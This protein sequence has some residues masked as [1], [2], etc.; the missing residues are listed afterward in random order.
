[1][2]ATSGAGFATA[3]KPAPASAGGLARAGGTNW[4][5]MMSKENGKPTYL[6]LLSSILSSSAG[7]CAGD[8]PKS[9][10]VSILDYVTTHEWTVPGSFSLS[11]SVRSGFGV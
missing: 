2:A 4:E 7:R 9:A 3:C 6:R 5:A 11:Q 10:W 1:M 8:Y